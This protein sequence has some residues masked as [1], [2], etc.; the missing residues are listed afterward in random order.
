M[1]YAI[2]SMAVIAAFVLFAAPTVYAQGKA[3]PASEEHTGPKV[4]E[5]APRF[6]LKDKDGAEH[7]LD[8]L[9]KNGKLALVFYRSA[10][11]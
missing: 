7:S 6:A 8:E 9:L 5:K 4:G 2:R 3:K 10:D 11:W 1:S